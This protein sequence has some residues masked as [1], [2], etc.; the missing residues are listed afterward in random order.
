M[1]IMY[2][3][4][5]NSFASKCT[6]KIDIICLRNTL[7]VS[8]IEEIRAIITRVRELQKFNHLH[9]LINIILKI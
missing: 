6:L 7:F 4:Q 8:K 2:E 3:I 5:K 1:Y 9:V